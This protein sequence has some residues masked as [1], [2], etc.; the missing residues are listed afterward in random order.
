M[1]RIWTDEVYDELWQHVA[2]EIKKD[3]KYLRTNTFKK[4]ATIFAQKIGTLNCYGSKPWKAVE[5]QIKWGLTKQLSIT[6]E[7]YVMTMFSNKHFAHKYGF[8]DLIP[9]Y[10]LSDY[11]ESERLI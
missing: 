8:K 5:Q 7:G 9:K 2:I 11:K 6:D 1:K 3:P 4:W 10:L